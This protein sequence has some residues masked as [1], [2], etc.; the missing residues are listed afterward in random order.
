MIEDAWEKMEVRYAAMKG[1]YSIVVPQALLI[2]LEEHLVSAL[3]SSVTFS[4][5]TLSSVAFIIYFNLLFTFRCIF[6][7]NLHS[8]ACNSFRLIPS[9]S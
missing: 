4:V 3:F 2:T 6:P 9:W 7:P 1:T 5:S 8:A